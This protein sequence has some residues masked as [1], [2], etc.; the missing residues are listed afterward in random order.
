MEQRVA[1]QELGRILVGRHQDENVSILKLAYC[2][3]FAPKAGAFLDLQNFPPIHHPCYAV[4]KDDVYGAHCMG[5]WCRVLFVVDGF[6]VLEHVEGYMG[7]SRFPVVRFSL[8]HL[9]D[10]LERSS[11][12]QPPRFPEDMQQCWD[13]GMYMYLEDNDI[14]E[15]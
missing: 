6:A 13:E 15:D 14:D 7:F 8:P 5:G 10:C 2:V 4:A 11:F 12:S 3:E 1:S 9:L